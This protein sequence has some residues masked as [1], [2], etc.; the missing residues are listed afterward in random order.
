MTEPSPQGRKTVLAEQPLAWLV[1]QHGPLEGQVFAVPSGATIGTA[2]DAHVRLEG[3]IDVADV[4]ARLTWKAGWHLVNMTSP[5]TRVGEA[6]VLP[7]ETRAVADGAVIVIG[8]ASLV[9]RS[10]TW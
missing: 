9:F 5:D 3:Y 2:H 10:F 4:H 8:A 7:L 6:A 1:P